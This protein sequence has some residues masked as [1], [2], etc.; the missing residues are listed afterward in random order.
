[1]FDSPD[2]TDDILEY[3]RQ[4]KGKLIR[5]M[6]MIVELTDRVKDRTQSR[7]VRGQLLTSLARLTRQKKVIRYRK[8]TMVRRRPRS[9]QG[10]IRISEL[11]C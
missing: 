4:R 11:I 6:D 2:F 7:K 1:M 10:L 9:A 3:L 5:P 8:V